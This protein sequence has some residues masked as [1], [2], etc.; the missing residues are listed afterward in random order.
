M[1]SQP[2][3]RPGLPHRIGLEVLL[4][5]AEGLEDAAASTRAGAIVLGAGDLSAWLRARVRTSFASASRL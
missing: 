2:V 5:E 3:A 1:L 4:E